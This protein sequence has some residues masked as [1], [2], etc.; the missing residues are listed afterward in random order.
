MSILKT[1]DM[2]DCKPAPTPVGAKLESTEDKI[3]DKEL[4][5]SAIG[6]LIYLSNWS[7]PDITYAVNLCARYSSNPFNEHW[8]AVKRILRYLKGTIGYGIFYTPSVEPIHAFCDADWAGD[9]DSR[10]STSGYCFM[11]AD[12]VVSWSNRKQ[13]CVALSSAEAEYISMS[14]AAQE[15]TWF[16]QLLRDAVSEKA[17]EPL[18]I[19]T[20]SQSAIA[21]AHNP[22]YHGRAKHIDIK[23]HFVRDKITD[24]KIELS[25]VS[26]EDMTADI[27]TKGLAILKFEKFRSMLN[28][29]SFREK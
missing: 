1:F 15:A 11:M 7:R 5:Q 25:Y 10:K 12:G 9:V 28:V 14:A 13:P 24:G 16:Q 19:Y 3:A 22:K 18:T 26:T 29:V 2:Q 21:I 8:I 4:Y 6:K 27:F 17:T 20:D 23:F